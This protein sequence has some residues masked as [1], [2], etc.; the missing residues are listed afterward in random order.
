M[1]AVRVQEHAHTSGPSLPPSCS[2]NGGQRELMLQAVSLE[3]IN[4]LPPLSPFLPQVKCHHLT[5]AFHAVPSKE[6][7]LIPQLSPIL[8]SASLQPISW[9]V[10][11]VLLLT[12]SLV[13]RFFSNILRI[14][15]SVNV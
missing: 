7:P 5:E 9:F 14:L 13:H 4:L 15:H 6:I 10:I 3:T 1:N 12:G 2:R 8:V 11:T